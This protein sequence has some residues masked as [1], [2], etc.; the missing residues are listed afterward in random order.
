MSRNERGPIGSLVVIRCRAIMVVCRRTAPHVCMRWSD[1]Q[2]VSPDYCAVF[3]MLRKL[4]ISAAVPRIYI[5]LPR[6]GP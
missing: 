6:Q 3:A 5:G 1:R 2:D 4:L